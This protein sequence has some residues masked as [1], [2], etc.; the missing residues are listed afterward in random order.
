MAET[1]GNGIEVELGIRSKTT[2]RLGLGD[3]S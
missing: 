1:R 3:Q 2:V